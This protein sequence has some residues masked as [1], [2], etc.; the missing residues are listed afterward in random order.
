MIAEGVSYVRTYRTDFG[1]EIHA[2]GLDALIT[3][4]EAP[5]LHDQR[6]SSAKNRVILRH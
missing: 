2:R 3:R 1:L 4:L 5:A 6:Q